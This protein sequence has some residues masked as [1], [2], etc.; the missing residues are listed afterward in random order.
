MYRIE[1]ETDVRP[2]WYGL[3]VV[4]SKP[5]VRNMPDYEIEK[6]VKRWLEQDLEVRVS[7][8][9]DDLEEKEKIMVQPY[10]LDADRRAH[11]GEKIFNGEVEIPDVIIQNPVNTKDKSNGGI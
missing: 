2:I 4:M 11:T 1:R 3:G 10:T 6:Y 9:I 8:K 7:D 5:D